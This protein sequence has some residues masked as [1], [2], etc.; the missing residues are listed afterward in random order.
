MARVG[1]GGKHGR[2]I[3]KKMAGLKNLRAYHKARKDHTAI[4]SD[5]SWPRQRGMIVTLIPLNVFG[6]R[7]G[8]KHIT[9]LNTLRNGETPRKVWSP[10]PPL[11]LGE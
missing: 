11:N 6:V 10:L 8:H 9:S 3:M 4:L 1:G 7:V 5:N 2:E